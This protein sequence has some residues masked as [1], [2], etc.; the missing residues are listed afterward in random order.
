MILKAKC[1]NNLFTRES[2][3]IYNRDSSKCIYRHLNV[4][5]EYEFEVHEG[6]SFNNYTLINTEHKEENFLNGYRFGL[7]FREEFENKSHESGIKVIVPI[8]ESYDF[9]LFFERV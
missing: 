2:S 7:D 5:E 6:D 3:M 1:K 9:N 4:G 8:Y